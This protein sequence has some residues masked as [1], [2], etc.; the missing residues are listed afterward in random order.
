L[1]LILERVFSGAIFVYQLLIFIRV[2][3]TWVQTDPYRSTIDHPLVVLLQRVTDPV[4]VPLRRMI[5]L[6][7]GT[8]DVSP[9]AALVLLEILRRIL[10]S[11]LLGLAS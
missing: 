4:L 5:P 10:S 3:L 11:A 2:M 7:G 6:I 8:F 9:I 1:I